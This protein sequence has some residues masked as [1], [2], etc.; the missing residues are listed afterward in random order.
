MKCRVCGEHNNLDYCPNCEDVE[1]PAIVE[2][3]YEDA[4]GNVYY[5]DLLGHTQKGIEKWGLFM[6][7]RGSKFD[8]DI[9]DSMRA[10]QAR[11]S[12]DA[13]IGYL[14]QMAKENR[15]ARRNG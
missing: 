11:N 12:R 13:M 9:W 15:W 8:V 4:S 2:P 14:T 7:L 1:P 3:A 5:V 10:A 6:R